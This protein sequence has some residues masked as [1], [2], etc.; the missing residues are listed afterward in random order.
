MNTQS[1]SIFHRALHRFDDLVFGSPRAV[2]VLI[3]LVT[4]FFATRIPGVRMY[5]D[6]ADLLPQLHP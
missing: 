2:L 5:S 1:K 6:F 4:A 3:L